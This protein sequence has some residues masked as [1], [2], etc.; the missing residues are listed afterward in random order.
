[1]ALRSGDQ[2]ITLNAP[3]DTRVEI[4]ITLNISGSTEKMAEQES[5]E[6][7]N[8]GGKKKS[9]PKGK[10][11]Q[12]M[13]TVITYFEQPDIIESLEDGSQFSI[14]IFAGICSRI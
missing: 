10:I 8:G 5:A 12:F 13:E 3:G 14:G 6:I 7:E 11:D 2:S 4:S 1:M 9:G